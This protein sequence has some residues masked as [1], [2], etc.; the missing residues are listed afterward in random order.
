MW[1]KEGISSSGASYGEH[2]NSSSARSNNSSD[3]GICDLDED[4]SFVI[5]ENSPAELVRKVENEFTHIENLGEL[6]WDNLNCLNC[7]KPFNHLRWK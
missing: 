1:S 3:S 6:E 5:T 4:Y 7:G 2:Y